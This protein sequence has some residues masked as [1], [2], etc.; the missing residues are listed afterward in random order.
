MTPLRLSRVHE[1]WAIIRNSITIFQ[2]QM[3]HIWII[4]TNISWKKF[5][6][7]NISHYT[8][9][10]SLFVRSFVVF[11]CAKCRNSIVIAKLWSQNSMW[12]W[13]N[14]IDEARS[15][16][17]THIHM[18]FILKVFFSGAI[19]RIWHCMSNIH[20]TVCTYKHMK[21]YLNDAKNALSHRTSSFA[22]E[23]RERA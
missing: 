7:F 10:F 8:R 21:I 18:Y 6:C 19:R 17:Y 20:Q 12:Y 3:K 16:C 11:A 23:S 9:L 13:Y 15:I 1:K 4:D 5:S 14:F 22:I 2:R